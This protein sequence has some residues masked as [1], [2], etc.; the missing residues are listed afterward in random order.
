VFFGKGFGDLPDALS[1]LRPFAVTGAL[2][3][4]FPFGSGGTALAPDLTTGTFES[5]P[6]LGI[7]TVHW[8]FSVQYST[9]Y[10]TSRFNGGPPK[11]EPLNQVV[12]AH[13]DSILLPR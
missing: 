8:G 3:A 7:E 4:E 9:L 1:W 2:V 5:I 10:L 6:G 13:E 11:N 12:P